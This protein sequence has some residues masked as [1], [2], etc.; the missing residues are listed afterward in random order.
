MDINNLV[1]FRVKKA[2]NKD[3]KEYNAI[4]IKVGEV[5]KVLAFL[6]NDQYLLITSSLK[7]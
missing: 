5:E 6:T 2:T 3:G 7:K 4:I 1:E